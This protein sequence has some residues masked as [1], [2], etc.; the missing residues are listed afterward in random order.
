MSQQKI[1]P[2]SRLF[3]GNLATERTSQ[4][5]LNSIFSNY[6]RVLD[7][8][9]LKSY[10][11]VQFDNPQSAKMAV[12]HEHGRKVGGMKVGKS[13]VV[14]HLAPVFLSVHFGG[15]VNKTTSFIRIDLL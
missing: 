7:V 12:E 6:G 5:E 8:V 2:N 15:V 1:P 13:E 3:I 4:Q 14:C 10:G 9:L 11:F